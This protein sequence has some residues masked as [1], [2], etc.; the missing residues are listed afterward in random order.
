MNEENK[1]YQLTGTTKNIQ[2]TSY[3]EEGE[4]VTG[5]RTLKQIKALRD[6]PAMEVVEGDLGGFIENES[7]LSQGE[8]DDWVFPDGHRIA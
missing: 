8:D 7:C 6:I 2:V 1:K 4:E 5:T 3:D